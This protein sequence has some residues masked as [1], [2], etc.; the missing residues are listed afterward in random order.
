MFKKWEDFLFNKFKVFCEEQKKW[1]L[2]EVE[3]RQQLEKVWGEIVSLW[4]IVDEVE[5]K[6]LELEQNLEVVD[7]SIVMIE[8]FK[9]EIFC[10]FV[11]EY[12]FYGKEV[13]MQLVVQEV[14]VVEVKVEQL[15]KEFVVW[16]E[17]LEK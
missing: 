5:K 16:E 11:M 13:K 4:W 1:V 12:L 8:K 17:Q 2:E 10:F 6:R 9:V 7:I 3:F 14:V 15:F